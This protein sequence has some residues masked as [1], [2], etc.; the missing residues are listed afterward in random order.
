[1]TERRRILLRHNLID[2]EDDYEQIKSLFESSLPEDVA[3]W[4]DFHAQLVA[5]GKQFCRPTARGQACPLH[6]FP[7]D[8]HA[9]R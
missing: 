8:P 7:P 4:N 2:P 3:L 6:P 1:M 5:V 9:G